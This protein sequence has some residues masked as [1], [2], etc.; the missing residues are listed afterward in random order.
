MAETNSFRKLH[1]NKK[2]LIILIS[3]TPIITIIEYHNDKIL[4]TQRNSANKWH[5]IDSMSVAGVLGSIPAG[6]IVYAPEFMQT[7]GISSMREGYWST[8]LKAKYDINIEITAD[9][10]KY[11]DKNYIDKRYIITYQSQSPYKMYHANL[12]KDISPE[13]EF[14]ILNNERNGFYNEEKDNNGVIFRWAKKN[15]TLTICNNS[16]DGLGLEL[17]SK[18]RTDNFK[19]YPLRVCLLGLCSDYNL[20][21]TPTL[22]KEKRLF[23]QGCSSVN[24]E[25]KSSPV[26]A[27]SD[28][29]IM[30]FQLFD[31]EINKVTN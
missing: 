18:V 19:Q 23:P 29:R 31:I 25:T 17:T 24:F 4:S 21:N 15:S 13:Y 12:N 8:Y 28:S 1:S 20:N 10:N 5:A 9:K 26:F 16:K 3:I 6:S 14:F 22:I 27:P 30:H 11:L 2:F 7:G